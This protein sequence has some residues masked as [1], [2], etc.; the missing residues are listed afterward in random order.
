MG[1]STLYLEYVTC[2]MI[3]F[4]FGKGS[5]NFAFLFPETQ[6]ADRCSNSYNF[7]GFGS[8]G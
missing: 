5:Q 6:A 3:F 7:G 4:S 2:F 8:L 1:M